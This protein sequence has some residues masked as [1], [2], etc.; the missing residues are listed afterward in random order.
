M[1][2]LI[3][4]ILCPTD[5]SDESYRAI[6]Y[7]AELARQFGATVVLAHVVHVPSGELHQPDGRTLTFREAEQR[8]RDKLEELRQQRLLSC[9]GAHVVAVEVG[10]PYEQLAEVARRLAVDLI[11]TST[12]G[13]T[14]LSHLAMGSVAE[15][16]IRHAPCPLLVVR[17]PAG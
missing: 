15:K 1:A 4:K 7:A 2:Q 14:G 9:P 17:P 13:R 11:V 5:F 8:S 6:D 3:R 12:H 16:L 10:D